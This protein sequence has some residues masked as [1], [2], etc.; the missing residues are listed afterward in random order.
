M[1]S[2]IITFSA[3]SLAEAASARARPRRAC[4]RSA[5]R[6]RVPLIG[7]RHAP[8]ARGGAGTAPGERLQTAPH[9]PATSAAWRGSSAPA[10]RAN[11]S[12]GS[13]CQLG[14]EPQAEV[15]LEDLAGGD[16]LAALVDRG[17]CGPRRRAARAAKVP[18]A[19]TGR[20]GAPRGEPRAQQLEAGASAR[21]SRSV[22]PQ[23]LEPPAAVGVAAAARGR[24]RRAR[25]R[26]AARAAAAEAVRARAVRRGRS[27]GSRTSRRR[28]RR[29]AAS[30]PSDH[31]AAR[32]SSVERVL[33]RRRD[34]AAAPSPRSRRRPPSRR[35]A[36]TGARRRARAGSPRPPTAHL[37]ARSA[38]GAL[39]PGRPSLS[40]P[41]P[42]PGRPRR[43]P[44]RAAAQG[45]G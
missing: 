40:P 15:R 34:H 41:R 27:R 35:P 1:R 18:D 37:R 6:G 42:Q 33:V 23:R 2:T 10:A 44:P 8:R 29:A 38:P 9:G 17:R 26:A 21:A 43:R 13:P 22:G 30:A 19:H 39:V 11:R 12:S 25:S 36:R 14:L 4:P 3:R 31:A 45:R 28:P 24:R 16:A 5:A 20:S 32:S 7:S